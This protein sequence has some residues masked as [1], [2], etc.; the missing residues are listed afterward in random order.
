LTQSFLPWSILTYLAVTE[1]D[2]ENQIHSGRQAHIHTWRTGDK[3]ANAV[4][5]GMVVDTLDC[6]FHEYRRT[7]LKDSKAGPADRMNSRA[8]VGIHGDDG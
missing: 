8:R 1:P 2:V 3:D 7:W 5:T 6:M 4:G